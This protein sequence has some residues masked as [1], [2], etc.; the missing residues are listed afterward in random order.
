[1]TI[2]GLGFVIAR[3]GL[4]LEVLGRAAQNFQRIAIASALGAALA[5]V[6]AA[7]TALAAVQFALFV[8]LLGPLELPHPRLSIWMSLVLAALVSL[9]GF[10][11]SAYIAG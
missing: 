2:I 7:M 10:V 8:R 5:L 4:F 3:F 11:L 6:G 1:M 9:V